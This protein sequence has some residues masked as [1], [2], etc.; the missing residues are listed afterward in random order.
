VESREGATLGRNRHVK[1]DI[2]RI[3]KEKL[4]ITIRLC[5]LATILQSV[6][7]PLKKADLLAVAH[8]LIGISPTAKSQLWRSGTRLEAKKDS[9]TAQELLAN[10]LRKRISAEEHTSCIRRAASKPSISGMVISRTTTSGRSSFAPNTAWIPSETSQ[11][12]Q[13]RILRLVPRRF[14]AAR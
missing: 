4:S 12:L 11:T 10:W 6:S 13:N 5:V 2:K 8:C 9:E 3:E 7:D 14:P 1:L